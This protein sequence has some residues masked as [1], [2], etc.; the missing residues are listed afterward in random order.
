MI[1]FIANGELWIENAISQFSCNAHHNLSDLFV[2][3]TIGLNVC[4]NSRM[5][6]VLPAILST[7]IS[8]IQMPVSNQRF[9]GQNFLFTSD[10]CV[11]IADTDKSRNATKRTVSLHLALYKQDPSYTII[12]TGAWGDHRLA[13]VASI[14]GN[15]KALELHHLAGGTA[16]RL[17]VGFKLDYL[18]EVAARFQRFEAAELNVTFAETELKEYVPLLTAEEK[19]ELIE[20]KLWNF[21]V[22]DDLMENALYFK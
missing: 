11:Y 16:P 17:W 6:N 14:I 15:K 2:A 19:A 22:V 18:F 5:A 12:E 10:K 9:N 7:E 1:M 21:N 4:C 8:A 20:K 3:T 13:Y